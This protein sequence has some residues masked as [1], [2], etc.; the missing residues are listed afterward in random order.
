MPDNVQDANFFEIVRV[1]GLAAGLLVLVATYLL[2]RFV[3]TALQGAG[4]RW[5]DRRLLINQIATLVR[6]ALWLAGLGVATALTVNLTREVL[7]AIGGTAAVTIGFALKDLAASILAGVII[8]IDRPFQVGD[9]VSFSGIYGEIA[10]IGLRSVRLVT[11]DDNVVTIPNNKFLTEV[12]SSGNWGALDMMIQMDFYVAVDQ[13]TSLAESLVG[14]ALTSC[15]YVYTKK[16]WVVLVNQVLEH[17]MVAIRL[18]A[19]AYVLDVQYEKAFETDVTKR[20]LAAFHEHH[21]VP[22]RVMQRAV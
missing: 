10:S 7:L 13:D 22:P 3:T 5:V 2:V 15:R 16:P 18:R 11:L 17:G 12:V 4:A 14:D 20:V 21:I 1:G 19:K 6:F 8:I 9:R